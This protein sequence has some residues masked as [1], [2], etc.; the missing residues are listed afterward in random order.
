MATNS[1]SSILTNSYFNDDKMSITTNTSS[2]GFTCTLKSNATWPG[3]FFNNN[4]NN[5]YTNT[6][7]N[8]HD[9]IL[10][11]DGDIFDGNFY[12]VTIGY[13]GANYGYYGC[14]LSTTA[15][16]SSLYPTIKNL[17]VDLSINNITIGNSSTIGGGGIIFS[18]ANIFSTNFTITNCHSLGGTIGQSSGGIC[19]INAGFNGSCNISNCYSTGGT[20]GQSSG[21]ICGEYA[22]IS[23]ICN[24]SSCYSTGMINSYGGGICGA[25]AGSN[26]TCIISN[27]YASGD[28]NTSD[29]AGGI[30]GQ[31]TGTSG[32]CNI[33]NC[34]YSGN[35][36]GGAIIDSYNATCNITNCY[37]IGTSTASYFIGPVPHNAITLTDCYGTCSRA[38]NTSGISG[39]Y[40]QT[41]FS[42]DWF[43]ATTLN[44][45]STYWKDCT[46]NG[47]NPSS[48]IQYNVIDPITGYA[49]SS[50]PILKNFFISRTNNLYGYRRYTDTPTFSIPYIDKLQYVGSSLNT[51]TIS[52]YVYTLYDNAIWPDDFT[53]NG[54][55]HTI[56]DSILLNDSTNNMWTFDGNNHTITISQT[57]V[58]TPLPYLGLFTGNVNK[59]GAGTLE[60][61]ITVKNLTIAARSIDYEIFDLSKYGGGGIY[62][63]TDPSG[64]P[65]YIIIDNCHT[66][67]SDGAQ[68]QLLWQSGGII[69]NNAAYNGTCII[70][71]CTSTGN[72]YNNYSTYGGV[73]TVNYQTSL[74]GGIAGDSAGGWTSVSTCIISNCYTT[75]DICPIG[76]GI[77]GSNA[78]I[79][80]GYCSITNCYSTGNIN[81][82]GGGITGR[83]PG[84]GGMCNISNCY[85]LGTI[86]LDA[87]GITGS[88][89]AATYTNTVSNSIIPGTC[90]I[91]NCYSTGAINSGGGIAGSRTTQCNTLNISNCYSTG[92]LNTNGGAIVAQ[93]ITTCFI[94]NCYYAGQ[95][96]TTSSCY[97]IGPNSTV[98]LASNCYGTCQLGDNTTTVTNSN[99]FNDNYSNLP[100]VGT[101]GVSTWFNSTALNLNQPTQYNWSKPQVT[102]V[103]LQYP[104][105]TAFNVDPWFGYTIYTDKPTFIQPCFAEGTNI[106]TP[107]GYLKVENLKIN[108]ILLTYQNKEI[109]I[110]DI[111]SFIAPSNDNLLYKLPKDALSLNIPNEDLYMSEGHAFRYNNN[112]YHMYHHKLAIKT[113]EKISVKYYHILIDNWFDNTLVANGVEVESYYNKKYNR[114]I[115]LQ[116]ICDE[117]SCK[118]KKIQSLENKIYKNESCNITTYS[119]INKS[120]KFNFKIDKNSNNLVITNKN[121][122]PMYDVNLPSYIFS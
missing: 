118:Y 115:E 24:I 69:G 51:P 50:I 15:S 78:A 111:Y 16:V 73:D 6:N 66:I 104:I 106:L 10:L 57:D 18:Y 65:N 120:K 87:G 79:N 7:S 37:Y 96:T 72:S 14:L 77:V 19:G 105:L 25:N 74:A 117:F 4:N 103:N 100:T 113:E 59:T 12:N 35:I 80:T 98:T 82:Q 90:N 85:S 17:G 76:G 112:W 97:F 110:K 54:Q 41:T 5:N 47:T 89:A 20:I 48:N 68:L 99:L 83:Q 1:L 55:T 93:S 27:C 52:N 33:I 30:C 81:S 122:E 94:S 92:Q 75:G 32:I 58:T 101:P 11:L 70:K 109:K 26:G 64:D 2:S 38:A 39:T 45:G 61:P 40:T 8:Y 42:S 31:Y 62:C 49:Y 95:T 3:D 9:P 116:W 46:I 121:G 53:V 102:G 63:Y 71:N 86:S 119:N 28:Q 108:D 107:F 67:G 43:S 56:S 29:S 84:V 88:S 60:N 13:G 44:K 21:G 22:G 114:N 36:V 91:T 34:F 23:G